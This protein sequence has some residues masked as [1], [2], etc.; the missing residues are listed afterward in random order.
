MRILVIDDSAVY[1]KL[2]CSHLQ[3]WN[4]AVQAVSDAEGAWDIL[5][6]AQESLILIADW[7]LPGMS[8][9]ELIEKVRALEGKPYMYFLVLTAKTEK[10]DLVLA[11]NS[12]ADDYLSKPLHPE[13]LRA[14]VQVADRTLR[15]HQELLETNKRLLVLASQDP[16]TGL[17][18]R[19]AFM[20]SFRRERHRALRFQS[21]ITLVMCDIDHFKSINDRFGHATGDNVIKLVARE[22][23]DASRGSDLVARMGGDEFILIMPNSRVSGGQILVDRVRQKLANRSQYK[24][25]PI[26]LSFGVAE[27]DLAQ[28]EDIAIHM[29]DNAMYVAKAEGRDR[30]HVAING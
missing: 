26:S 20:D 4:Y 18:N 28:S 8:G 5:T 11:L 24:D 16:L 10:E 29:V 25:L 3:D 1:R 27:M 2:L 13:E 12:G 9:L 14:R 6:H 17:Q 23:Q 19:R 21:P 30:V 7:E 22:L 15:L